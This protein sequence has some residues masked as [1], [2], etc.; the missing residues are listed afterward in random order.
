M[1]ITEHNTSNKNSLAT[2]AAIACGIGLL[3]QLPS[4][5]MHL[6]LGKWIY[7]RDIIL[8]L[9][10]ALGLMTDWNGFRRTLPLGDL[11]I[12]IGVMTLIIGVCGI[13]RGE[14][15]RCLI[16]L[17]W[18]IIWISSLFCGYRLMRSFGPKSIVICLLCVIAYC[19]CE[20][21]A[22]QLELRR[23][24]YLLNIEDSEETILGEKLVTSEYLDQTLRVRGMQRNVF[25]FA[26]LMGTAAICAAMLAYYWRRHPLKMA[27]AAALTPVFL[28]MLTL[29]GGRSALIGIL[30]ASIYGVIALSWRQ[31][32]PFK[33]GVLIVAT[34]ILIAIISVTGIGDLISRVVELLP[35]K[36]YYTDVGSS[37]DRDD[38]WQDA[39]K[40]IMESPVNFLIGVPLGDSSADHLVITDNWLLYNIYHGGLLMF[41][42][43]LMAM[44]QLIFK[45]A[46][47][48]AFGWPAIVLFGFMAGEALARE[49]FFFLSAPVFF[50]VVAAAITETVPV[51]RS[52]FVRNRA[53]NLPTNLTGKR[54]GS[55]AMSA[56]NELQ[57]LETDGYSIDHQKV[58]HV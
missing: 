47:G 37:F 43:F 28:V 31:K 55:E 44:L 11:S 29:S 54:M 23:G 3:L 32:T 14:L 5:V 50:V 4:G 26:N 10:L 51:E 49:S 8:V 7:A 16:I 57:E 20:V 22:G 33:L 30:V 46:R 36:A 13:I 15:V 18:H 6:Y 45:A 56:G 34:W 35:T 2:F 52:R 41:V 58:T 40:T 39:S 19:A 9:A 53:E 25:N 42:W 12:Y 38:V 21:G 17:M 24:Q 27:A 48:P 1:P